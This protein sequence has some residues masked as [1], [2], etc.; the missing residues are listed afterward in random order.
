MTRVLEGCAL[1][2]QLQP[3][4]RLRH[5]AVERRQGGGG[6]RR[7]AK[8]GRGVALGCEVLCLGLLDALVDVAAGGH[9][10]LVP[11]LDLV[12]LDLDLRAH[13]V[14]L[15]LQ[16]L[17]VRLAR[18][19]HLL[20]ELL[21]QLGVG[22]QTLLRIGDVR[23]NLQCLGAQDRRMGLDPVQRTHE[24]EVEFVVGGLHRGLRER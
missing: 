12:L 15:I 17:L 9:Q 23:L 3:L 7:H 14:Q 5:H 4:A 1:G 22:R 21:Q 19:A 10:V 16:V 13:Q 6:G 20:G 24:G 2:A 8:R 18:L 11:L